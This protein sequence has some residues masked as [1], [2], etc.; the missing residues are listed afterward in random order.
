M[1]NISVETWLLGYFTGSFLL[2]NTI[3][4]IGKKFFFKT[5]TSSSLCL[6]HFKNVIRSHLRL[7][8]IIAESKNRMD[9]Y[10]KKGVI[11][12]VYYNYM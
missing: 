3:L 12:Y 10:N 8:K 2:L 4:L 7:E 11:F 9:E 5:K 6:D 1:I